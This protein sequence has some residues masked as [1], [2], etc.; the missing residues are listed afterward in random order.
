MSDRCLPVKSCY[1]TLYQ[2]K[3]IFM[4]I[5]AAIIVIIF[6]NCQIIVIYLLYQITI[7]FYKTYTVITY[8]YKIDMINLHNQYIQ[9]E[10]IR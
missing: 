3:F 7:Y 1:I 5:T 10:V 9:G 8:R 4:V 2:H 6:V